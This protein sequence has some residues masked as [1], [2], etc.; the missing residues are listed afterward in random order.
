MDCPACKRKVDF[1]GLFKVAF[2]KEYVCPGCGK[3]SVKDSNRGWCLYGALLIFGWGADALL[4]LADIDSSARFTLST[5]LVIVVGLLL[6]HFFEK[7]SI[8]E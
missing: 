4:R 8:V 7:L 5:F 6:E 3:K 2:S 1:K